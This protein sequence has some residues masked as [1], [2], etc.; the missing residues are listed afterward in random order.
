MHFT[1]IHFNSFNSLQFTSLEGKRELGT[2]AARRSRKSCGDPYE[3]SFE[4]RCRKVEWSEASVATFS[5]RS[6]YLGSRTPLG[7]Q[8]S[9]YPVRQERIL[10]ALEK[11][12]A[13][14]GKLFLARGEHLLWCA[15]QGSLLHKKSISLAQEE[16][17]QEVFLEGL[18]DQGIQCQRSFQQ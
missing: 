8:R 16:H 7:A 18:R 2:H 17:V 1:S 10:D 9:V 3:F 14:E 5:D 11:K 13:Q 6:Q 4:P 12:G 15:R